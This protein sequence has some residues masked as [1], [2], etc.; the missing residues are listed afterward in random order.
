MAGNTDN[1]FDVFPVRLKFNRIVAFPRRSFLVNKVL[2][3]NPSPTYNTNP[4]SIRVFAL[5]GTFITLHHFPSESGNPVFIRILSENFQV[6]DL[7][8]LSY[9]KISDSFIILL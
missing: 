7:I 8:N 2:F 6:L 1:S 3:A 9:E 5:S 4:H